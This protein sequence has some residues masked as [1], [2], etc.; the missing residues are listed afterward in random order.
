M[1]ERCFLSLGRNLESMRIYLVG[2]DFG[3]GVF[4]ASAWG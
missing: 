2:G 3:L 1:G 4:Q